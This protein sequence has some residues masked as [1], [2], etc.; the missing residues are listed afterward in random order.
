MTNFKTH[1]NIPG[2]SSIQDK[3]GNS[4]PNTVSTKVRNPKMNK[5]NARIKKIDLVFKVEGK[6][7][8]YSASMRI[9]R[10]KKLSHKFNIPEFG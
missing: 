1:G 6:I 5:R 10:I 4:K 2:R 8:K 7:Q 3:K 9:Q